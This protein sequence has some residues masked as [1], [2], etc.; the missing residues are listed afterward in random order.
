MEPLP[1]WVVKRQL[2]KIE[3][4]DVASADA[5]MHSS[6]ALSHNF[7]VYL[8]LALAGTGQAKEGPGRSGAFFTALCTTFRNQAF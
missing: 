6:V 7:W 2:N 8:N 4:P 5:G 3:N 1:E